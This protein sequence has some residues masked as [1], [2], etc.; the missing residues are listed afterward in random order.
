LTLIH[1]TQNWSQIQF[2][3][4]EEIPGLV[5]S[6]LALLAVIFLYKLLQQR[7]R[8]LHL[9]RKNELQYK[10]LIEQASD[11]IFLADQQGN[12]LDINTQG[13]KLLGY[14]KEEL[15]QLNLRDLIP[16]DE[17]AKNPL[18][19]DRLLA[20]ETVVSERLLKHKQGTL[21][22]VEISA[23]MLPDGRLQG[24]VRDI[25]KR[26]KARRALEESEARYRRL[27]EATFEGVLIH[28]NGRIVDCN[29]QFATMFGYEISEL[30]GKDALQ[31]GAPEFRDLLREKMQ[32]GYEKPYEL[33]G[34][35][36]DGSTFPVEVCGKNLPVHGKMM[37]V[38]TVRDLTERKKAE[39]ELRRYSERLKI[40]NEMGKAILA[41]TSP[42]KIARETLIRLQKLIRYRRASVTLFDLERKNLQILVSQT[43]GESML[44]EHVEIPIKKHWLEQLSRGQPHFIPDVSQFDQSLPFLDRLIAESVKSVVNFPML[45]QQDLIGSLNLAFDVPNA[46]DADQVTIIKEVAN[47]L[48]IALH[49]ARLYQQIQLHAEEL[50]ARVAERTRALEEV[51][52]ELEA[53]AYSVSH[54]LRAP[55]RAMQGFSKALLEDFGDQLDE[56][57]KDYAHRIVNAARHMDLLIQDLLAYSRITHEKMKLGPVHLAAIVEAVQ[58][59]LQGEI[60]TRGARIHIRQPLMDVVAHAA[61]LT[62]VLSNLL[63][64]AMKFVPEGRSPEIRMWT[65]I[66]NGQVRFWI[67]DNGI[68]IDH[69][70]IDKIFRVF[71]RLHSIEAYPGTGIGLAI[72]RKA[73]ERMGGRVGVC[74]EPNQGSAFWFELPQAA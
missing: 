13:C 68:G 27:S 62:Q 30:I 19:L 65:E 73:I 12:Y 49:Q 28:D 31:L 20:G 34:V 46:W 6:L 42:E 70:H 54:D 37:R 3:F 63:D 69:R 11:G 4:I 61:T 40:L 57:G 52:S 48:A 29:Q 17:L 43:H 60:E 71:E 50:E 16:A 58:N 66:K 25:T 21:V 32:S 64:N 72:V 44:P 2:T 7:T 38:N 5:V 26:I 1:Y 41:A 53:F 24:I 51:N 59:Q 23:K 33:I 39:D 67:K 18:Q 22:P 9:A 45:A 10:T 56:V 74:S 55:L 14:G 15:L 36:K 47:E 35:R 8:A